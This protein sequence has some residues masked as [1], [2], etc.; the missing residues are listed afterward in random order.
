[1]K[2]VFKKNPSLWNKREAS[3]PFPERFCRL[4]IANP[5]LIALVWSVEYD[6]V[7]FG[8]WDESHVIYSH[9]Q[10]ESWGLSSLGENGVTLKQDGQGRLLLMNDGYFLRSSNGR[11]WSKRKF[12]VQ[13]PEDYPHPRMNSL[14]EV[15][16][17][18]GNIGYALIEHGHTHMDDYTS[19]VGLLKS[20]DDGR[21]WN[22]LHVF[23]G[24]TAGEMYGLSLE[25]ESR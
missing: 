1:M 7:W 6:D 13:W 20:T 15:T 2:R 25:V 19:D 12:R 18:E 23:P 4:A 8:Y 17:V 5:N 3:I 24:L 21:S 16:F 10:G 14:S 9:D 22:L 11:K